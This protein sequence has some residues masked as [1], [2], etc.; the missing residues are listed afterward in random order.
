MSLTQQLSGQQF[1][2]WFI[3]HAYVTHNGTDHSGFILRLMWDLAKPI[4]RL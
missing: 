2:R 1:L 3:V 4:R